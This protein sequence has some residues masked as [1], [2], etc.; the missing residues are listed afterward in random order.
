M[1]TRRENLL[2]VFGH[3]LPEWIPLCGHV[4]P[5]N[6]PS[7]EGMDPPLAAELGTV[8]WHDESTV[9]FSRYL[10]LDIMD[11]MPPPVSTTP[12]NAT[13][14]TI[15][16]GDQTV[17][18]WH[19]SLGDLRQVTRRCREDGT[20]YHVE[21]MVK[22]ADD[23]PAL[24]ALFEDT[25]ITENAE[26]AAAIRL[27]QRMIGD[28]GLLMCFMPGTAMGMMY[29]VYSGVQTLAYLCADAP[30]A[31]R[32]LFAVMEK[33]YQRQ[34]QIS[35]GSE[36]DALVAMDD[37]STTTIS[38]AMFREYNLE[39]TDRR[40]S[41]CHAAGK[42]YFHHSCGHIRDLLPLYRRTQMDAV[43][44]FTVPPTGNVTVAEGKT[45]LGD[46]MTIIAG[47]GQFSDVTWDLDRMRAG[48]RRL[49]QEAQPG[50]H[51]VVNL[52]A[53][54]HRTM[55]QTRAVVDECGRYQALAG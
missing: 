47:A 37:T 44:A 20:S 19:T 49:F 12:R 15:E 25:E 33:Q 34:F 16:D 26:A 51:F 2:R 28:D 46:R 42:L 6:Q 10:G 53:F 4:D 31:L 11:H 39:C 17:R 24:A 23:L 35:A 27:R 32:D 55:E 22:S 14:T 5:Y 13:M 9:R 52:A 41:V 54:P 48:V 8:Q 36:A 7:R 45:V 43:H 18:T 38:P 29:R 50:D 30:K 1:T 40:A 3:E 21:H